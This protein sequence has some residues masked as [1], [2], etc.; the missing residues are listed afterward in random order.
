MNSIENMER[1]GN[2]P[3]TASKQ[4]EESPADTQRP[5]ETDTALSV[6]PARSGDSLPVLLTIHSE[7]DIDSPQQDNM[8]LLTEGTMNLTPDC[9][10]LTYH[11]SALTGMEGTTTVFEMYGPKVILRRMG[12]VSS[13][14]IFEEGRQHTSLYE[15]PMGE[16][17]IDIQTG[18]LRNSVTESGG[19]LEIRYSV[20][21]EHASTGKN[22]F[23]M[24]VRRKRKESQREKDLTP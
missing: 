17:S 1:T 20:S 12:T 23:R 19:L 10:T 11:E 24:K 13:Q 22:R 4:E 6:L 7:Q 5:T 14:M 16:L 18:Y 15:T 2:T 9:L 8:E 21:V 3:S